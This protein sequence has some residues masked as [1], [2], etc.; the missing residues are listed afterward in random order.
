M[1]L[2]QMF[3]NGS[4]YY[5]YTNTSMEGRYNVTINASDVSGEF[6]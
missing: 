1:N 3:G 4:Y 5:V 6:Q 2:S